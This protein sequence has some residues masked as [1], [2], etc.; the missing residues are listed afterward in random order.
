[1]RTCDWRSTHA[2]H[3]PAMSPLASTMVHA[4]REGNRGS[5]STRILAGRAV[6]RAPKGI[7]VPTSAPTGTI[8]LDELPQLLTIPTTSAY[9]NTSDRT[10]RRM[11]ARGDLE[12]VRV[13]PRLIRVKRT[14]L[15]ALGR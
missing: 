15:E 2:C 12:A 8:A 11:I 10:V 7:L 5:D 14:S 13:G 3:R 9:L 6:R 1:M 4:T